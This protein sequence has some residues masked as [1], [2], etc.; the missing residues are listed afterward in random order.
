MTKRLPKPRSTIGTAWLGVWS[1]GSVGWCGTQSIS[2]KVI[3]GPSS[4]WK[5]LARRGDRAYLCRVSVW[6]VADKLGRPITR[7]K[8]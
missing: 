8:R 1:D 6:P 3:S 5:L 7:R 2:S 4:R